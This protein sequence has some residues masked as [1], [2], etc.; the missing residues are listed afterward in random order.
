MVHRALL[1]QAS[2]I[3][4]WK[5]RCSTTAWCQHPRLRFVPNSEG[6]F[7]HF[8]LD[9]CPVWQWW[10]TQNHRDI[11]FYLSCAAWKW[12]WC[13]RRRGLWKMKVARFAV[14]AQ[15]SY[16]DRSFLTAL[17]MSNMFACSSI[18]FSPLIFPDLNSLVSLQARHIS[19]LAS[20]TARSPSRV[21]ANL[22]SV[23]HSITVKTR[24]QMACLGALLALIR[25]VTFACPK[26]LRGLRFAASWGITW[27][28]WRRLGPPEVLLLVVWRFLSTT[29]S[30]VNYFNLHFV[31]L[32]ENFSAIYYCR[33]DLRTRSSPWWMKN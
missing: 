3:R 6:T 15:R 9:Q 17:R 30:V 25:V 8:F 5:V 10:R 32:K 23:V 21:A 28:E 16:L 27:F 4:S 33:K 20:K 13:R 26:W 7:D 24:R 31:L 22:T 29:W 11:L 12:M 14:S 2:Q 19:P 18:W 1:S